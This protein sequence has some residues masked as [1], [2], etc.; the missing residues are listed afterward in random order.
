MPIKTP[1]INV[2]GVPSKITK[3]EL[4]HEMFQQNPVIKKLHL[5]LSGEGKENF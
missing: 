4:K 1:T 3:D 2:V 5:D